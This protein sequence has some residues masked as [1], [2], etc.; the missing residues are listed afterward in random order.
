LSVGLR[1]SARARLPPQQ[2]LQECHRSPPSS[3]RWSTWE[4]RSSASSGSSSLQSPPEPGSGSDPPC[5]L[6][7]FR[8][9]RAEVEKSLRVGRVHW[10]ETDKGAMWEEGILQGNVELQKKMGDQQSLEEAST[11]GEVPCSHGGGGGGERAGGMGEISTQDDATQQQHEKHSQEQQCHPDGPTWTAREEGVWV[12][13]EPLPSSKRLLSKPPP[14]WS[15]A[16][17]SPSHQG[18]QLPKAKRRESLG[19]GGVG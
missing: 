19:G 2:N 7:A 18:N 11:F 3:H 14:C 13:T 6:Q 12:S 10:T 9:S 4:K 8:C 5:T 17:L 1:A 15:Q 16:P